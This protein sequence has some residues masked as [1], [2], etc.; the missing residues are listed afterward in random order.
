[1]NVAFLFPDPIAPYKGGTQRVTDILARGLKNLGHKVVYICYNSISLCEKED[2]LS[3]QQIYLNSQLKNETELRKELCNL[4]LK[5]KIEILICQLYNENSGLI[6]K[7]LPK[8][9]KI[10]TSYH[11]QPFTA[12]HMPR[13]RIWNFNPK[14]IRQLIFKIGSLIYPSFVSQ[15]NAKHEIRNFNNMFKDSYKICFISERFY[16]RV[17]KHIPDAP[18][19]KFVAINNPSTYPALKALPNKEKIILWVGRVTNFGKNAIDFIRV[20]MLL[21][22]NNPSWQ[23]IIIGDGP[24]LNYNRNYA[25]KHNGKRLTFAGSISNPEEYYAKSQFVISTSWSESWGMTLTEGMSFGCIPCAYDT[26]ETLHDIIDDRING[27]IVTPNPKSMAK[28]IQ[29]L[30]DNP[31]KILTMS[32]SSL[33]K[34]QLMTNNRIIE[35]WDELITSS[36][37]DTKHKFEKY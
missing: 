2:I 24:D 37:N 27:L 18:I 29:N 12:D 6:I 22:R 1:M 5:Y 8:H 23:A 25:K 11:T 32:I 33:N 7:N 34:M 3:V 17:L 4:V 28:R 10:I 31:D 14:N 20:W 36:Y 30:I 21:E 15:Y 13:M 19:K 9:V 16:K 26:Y 35:Q